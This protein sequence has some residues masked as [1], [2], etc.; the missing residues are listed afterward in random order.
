[1]LP[2]QL[3]QLL[4]QQL[5][6]LLLLL[7]PQQGAKTELLVFDWTLNSYLSLQLVYKFY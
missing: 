6:L 4:P 3:L 7:L 5:L 1:V 2:Q